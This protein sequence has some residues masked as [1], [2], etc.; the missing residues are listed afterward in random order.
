MSRKQERLYG[1]WLGMKNRTRNSNHKD[2]KYCGAKGITICEEW[3]KSYES[4]KAWALNNGYRDDLT[5]DRIDDNGNYCPENCRWADA[6]TQANNKSNNHLITYNGKTQNMTQWARE[7]GVSRGL[8]K[9]RLKSGWSV[10]DALTKEKREPG[11]SILNRF[12][13]YNGKTM[14]ASRWA[15]ELGINK[16]TLSYRLNQLGWSTEKALSTPVRKRG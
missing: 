14:T 6:Y 15:D 9:D 4:F 7:L 10:E 16:G 2:Y 12:L 5:I 8:I 1:V 13:T 11:E 3:D